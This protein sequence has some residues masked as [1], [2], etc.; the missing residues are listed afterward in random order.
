MHSHPKGTRK[1]KKEYCSS[2]QKGI[3]VRIGYYKEYDNRVVASHSTG[4]VVFGPG[5][6]GKLLKV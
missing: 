3:T 5:S 4:G 1:G 6:E 2:I